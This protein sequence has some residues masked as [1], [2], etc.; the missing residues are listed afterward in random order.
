MVYTQFRQYGQQTSQRNSQARNSMK[1]KT[2][3]CVLPAIDIS[4][5]MAWYKSQL[6]FEIL[7]V[8]TVNSI[9]QKAYMENGLHYLYL[10]SADISESDFLAHA[11]GD[12]QYVAEDGYR[13]YPVSLSMSIVDEGHNWDSAYVVDK[14]IVPVGI[15]WILKD[16]SNHLIKVHVSD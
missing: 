16:P 5:S 15:D 10:R 7:A 2:F 8:N 12:V 11:K 13:V 9:T 1:I 4:T 3:V 6:G 14:M